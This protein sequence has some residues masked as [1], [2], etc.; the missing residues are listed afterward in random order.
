MTITFPELEQ[1]QKD[2]LNTHKDSDCNYWYIVKSIR[3]CGKSVLAQIL[4]I[5]ASFTEGG[6]VSLCV[7]PVVSQARKMFEDILRIAGKLIVKSNGST[8]EVTFCN[9]SRILFRSA[10]QGDSIRGNTVKGSGILIVD[11]AA[12]IKDEVFYSVLVPTTNVN[13]NAIFVFS[14]PKFKSG[15]FYDLYIKG[16]NGGKNLKTFDWTQYD[17]SKYLPENMLEMYR[18]QM[19]KLSFAAEFLGEFIDAD[20]SVFTDFKKNLKDSRTN[21]NLPLYMGLDWGTGS[22]KDNTA[23]TL[24]QIQDNKIVIT[25]Q[26]AFNDK[27]ANQTT[28]YILSIVT[29][30]VNK[31]IKEIHIVCEKNSIG[32]IFYQ[33][34]ID[35]L[36]DFEKEY[37]SNAGW[38]DEIEINCTTFTTTNKSKEEIIK[39]TIVCLEQ[40]KIY[41][42]NIEELVLEMSAYE[43]KSSKTGLLTY[44]APSGLHDDRV[45][46]L[47]ILVG[48]M[49][50]E[51]E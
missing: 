29:G 13:H 30:L 22:G 28:D 43:C 41:L 21:Y 6:S 5:Y 49:F 10:E 35:R 51:L 12:Y 48:R 19:P 3:Q 25:D 9:G 8:L 26:I 38:N 2:V 4:L 27:N 37:N 40:D 14:T 11:E 45:M 42:P 1:W 33:L 50:N 24:G 23:I 44:N 20:G 18:Q 36:D 34:L 31:G 17:L 15:F 39:N 47:C 7:S 16:L 32:N 46:S